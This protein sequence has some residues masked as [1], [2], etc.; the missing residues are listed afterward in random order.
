MKTLNFLII[1]A[2]EAYINTKNGMII[3]TSIENV[4][5]INRIGK[6]ISAPDFVTVKEGDYVLVHHNIMR[7]KLDTKGHEIQS[8]YHLEGNK[9]FVPLKEVFMYKRG[10]KDWLALEPFCFVKPIPVEDDKNTLFQL[11]KEEKSYK[12]YEKNR[13]ILTYPNQQLLDQGLRAGQQVVFADDSEY[14]FEIEGEIFYKMNTRYVL[15]GE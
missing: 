10:D 1:E 12:G 2:E 7:K 14:E 13:G 6:V 9:Y 15:M 3:N 11:S 4:S 5:R 8:A